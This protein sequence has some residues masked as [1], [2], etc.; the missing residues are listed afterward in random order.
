MNKMT[1]N[2]IKEL[3]EDNDDLSYLCNADP[4][5]C[6][7]FPISVGK[8]EVVATRNYETS[9]DEYGDDLGDSSILTWT[10]YH[11]KDHDVFIKFQGWYSSYNG[12]EFESMQE[13][14]PVTKT[15]TVYE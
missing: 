11:F 14:K 15:I 12:I 1:Y 10:V 5:N 3:F 8:F 13:V 4:D 6:N 9:E 2:Q 7:D